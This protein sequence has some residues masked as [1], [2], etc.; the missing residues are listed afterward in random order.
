M[1]LQQVCC[2]HSVCISKSK[3]IHL[4]ISPISNDLLQIA[5]L[6]Y[7]VVFDVK[8]VVSAKSFLRVLQFLEQCEL[9]EGLLGVNTFVLMLSASSVVFLVLILSHHAPTREVR[10]VLHS[11]TECV[12]FDILDGVHFFAILLNVSTSRHLFFQPRLENLIIGLVCVNFVLP[13]ISLAKLSH[14]LAKSEKGAKRH[15]LRLLIEDDI[16]VILFFS[17]INLPYFIIRCILWSWMEL[18]MSVFLVKNAI[19]MVIQIRQVSLATP[20]SFTLPL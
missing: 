19:M 15:I 12:T 3:V 6:V 17:L 5:W 9:D 1:R 18:E 20:L 11:I 8:L 7:A 13:S 14:K 2:Q 10:E 16:S 4:G